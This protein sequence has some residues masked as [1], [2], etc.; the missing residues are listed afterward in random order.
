MPDT[1]N[2]PTIDSVM[3]DMKARM[4]KSIDSLSREFT[5]I[6]STRAST[7]MVD[8]IQVEYY[9]SVMP[10][11]QLATVSIPEPRM[12][13][14]TPFDKGA[15]SEIEKSIM[16]SD[17]NITPQNDGSVIRLVLPELTMERRKEL[18]KQ[19]KQKLE[20]SKV[21]MRNIRRDAND[22]TKKLSGKGHSEDEIKAAQ[23]EIQKVTNS[24]I[25]KADELASKK[26][27]SILEV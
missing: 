8:H 18:V 27:A 3:K 14:L 10:L 19:V 5:A 16:K 23:D 24:F 1:D 25:A 12:I 22:D 11:N 13:M 20:E 26:E 15:M 7:S 2:Q 21:S 9:G 17:L 6:R 4:E